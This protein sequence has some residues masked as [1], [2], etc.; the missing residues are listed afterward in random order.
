MNWYNTLLNHRRLDAFIYNVQVE[1]Y[2]AGV[3]R[4]DFDAGMAPYN[5]ASFNRWCTLAG[6]IT[7]A[8]VERLR[9]AGGAVLCISAE[10]DPAVLKPATAAEEKL[11]RQLADG[12]AAAAAA[13]QGQADTGIVCSCFPYFQEP[14]GERDDLTSSSFKPYSF[15]M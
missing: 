13:Q 1:R 2:V 14:W 8:D 11:Y 3:K 12:R 15:R 7:E 5:L 10:A 9:P 6:Y 4:F